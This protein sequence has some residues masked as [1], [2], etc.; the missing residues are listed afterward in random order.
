MVAC[1]GQCVCFFYEGSVHDLLGLVCFSDEIYLSVV[2]FQT[3]FIVPVDLQEGGLPVNFFHEVF[4]EIVVAGQVEILFVHAQSEL[5]IL[6]HFVFHRQ[7]TIYNF[8]GGSF[9]DFVN[10]E[11][12]VYVDQNLIIVL[13]QAE[14]QFL[15]SLPFIDVDGE[16]YMFACFF[17]FLPLGQSLLLVVVALH[18][19]GEQ[20]EIFL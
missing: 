7:N 19:G 8:S 17:Q 15:R 9:G 5:L 14:I 4:Q 6:P 1:E 2:D 16:H 18:K 11:D 3:V 10:P 20:H 12:I 13:Y